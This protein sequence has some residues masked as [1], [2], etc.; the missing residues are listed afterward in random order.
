MTLGFLSTLRSDV[1][2]LAQLQDWYGIWQMFFQGE[3]MQ[4]M[5]MRPGINQGSIWR[6]KQTSNPLIRTRTGGLLCRNHWNRQSG[7]AIMKMTTWI[8]GFWEKLPQQM[9][10]RG[11]V[12]SL[13]SLLRGTSFEGPSFVCS[14][15]QEK[16]ACPHL[17]PQSADLTASR[18]WCEESG[19][20]YSRCSHKCLLFL[21]CLSKDFLN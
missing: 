12:S 16:S 17:L 8:K 14:S 6:M 3:K 1:K 10:G 18:Q 4:N 9:Y 19:P 13:E 20:V 2:V 21:T 5:D 15:S 11:A 7:L